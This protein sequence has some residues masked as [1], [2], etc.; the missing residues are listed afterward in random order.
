[1]ADANGGF[2]W[3]EL[4]TTDPAAAARFYGDVVGWRDEDS[5]TPGLDYRILADD[6]GPAGGVLRISQDGEAN[7]MKPVW[8]GYIGVVDVDAAVEAIV[9]EGGRLHMPPREIPGVGPI[10]MVTDPQGIPFYLM[11]G[12]SDEAS[13]AF[14][15]CDP[16]R[17]SWNELV[18]TDQAAALDFY[19]RHF[20]F[21]RAG[22]MPM[23][24]GSDYVFIA[25][26][27][28]PIGAVMNRFQSED[29]AMWNYYFRVGDIDEAAQRV[30]SGGG[31]VTEGPMEVPGGDF[32]VV[33][34]DPQ[35]AR[36]GL[37]GSRG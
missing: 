27:G 36:F 34:R 28:T 13:P 24:P 8:L 7:G 3:Y 12:A 1:M 33:G 6:R 5:G 9:A 4:M 16:G 22:A 26:H 37:V 18:T 35:G 11:R 20:G 31:E 23:G 25:H 15:P 19:G 10:A 29:R 2:R 32:V 21:E 17:V 14:S 30:R